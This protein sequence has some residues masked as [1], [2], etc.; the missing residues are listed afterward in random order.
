MRDG[1]TRL[2][3]AQL[4]SRAA[5]SGRAYRLLGGFRTRLTELATGEPS[6]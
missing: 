2:T 4:G 5:E 1:A 3:R 6:R